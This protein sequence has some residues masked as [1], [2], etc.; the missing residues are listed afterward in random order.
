[1]VTELQHP[2]VGDRRGVPEP[3]LGCI[4]QRPE[5]DYLGLNPGRAYLKQ[6]RNYRAATACSLERS[7]SWAATRT[8][9][10]PGQTLATRGLV[11]NLAGFLAVLH[12]HSTLEGVRDAGDPLGTPVP[13]ATTIE[14]RARFG[15]H[16]KPSK[17]PLGDWMALVG[18]LSE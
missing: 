12:D 13:Q 11:D 10:Q 2:S 18:L 15:K 6:P 14:I 16:V 3:W 17:C 8:R 4:R 9:R 7:S 1:M 5:A